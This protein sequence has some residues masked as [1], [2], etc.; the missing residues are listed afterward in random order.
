[1]PS[2]E[3]L[4]KLWLLSDTVLYPEAIAFIRRLV[5]DEE[6]APLPASQVMGLLNVTNIPR[7]SELDTFIKHQ[8]DRDW[9]PSKLD[10]KKF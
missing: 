9:T 8:R 2:A 5:Q 6:C 4:Q 7:Y 3:Q 10:I 1:M